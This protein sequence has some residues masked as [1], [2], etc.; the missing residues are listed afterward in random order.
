MNSGHPYL[1]CAWNGGPEPQ[2]LTPDLDDL[3][4]LDDL[5]DPDN[6]DNPDDPRRSSKKLVFATI[7]G[8]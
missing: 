8:T 6:L 1:R 4:N 2:L 7:R 5:N 3:D